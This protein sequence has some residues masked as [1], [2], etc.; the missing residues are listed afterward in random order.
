[1]SYLLRAL[2]KSQTDRGEAAM[3]EGGN[4]AFLPHVTPPAPARTR[5]LPLLLLSNGVLLTLI[6]SSLTVLYFRWADETERAEQLVVSARDTDGVSPQGGSIDA[7]GAGAPPKNEA[8]IG[9]SAEAPAWTAVADD[10]GSAGLR[11][12]WVLLKAASG[13]GVPVDH[14]WRPGLQPANWKTPTKS[15]FGPPQARLAL[16]PSSGRIPGG[17]R[18]L[19]LARPQQAEGTLPDPSQSPPLAPSALTPQV[20]ERSQAVPPSDDASGARQPEPALGEGVDALQAAV[21]RKSQDLLDPGAAIPRME[22]LPLSVLRD[23]P[24][25]V[26]SVHAYDP[27]PAKRFVRLNRAKR[28]AGDRVAKDLWLRNVTPEGVILRYRDTDFI[29][30]AN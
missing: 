30:P 29:L 28:K 19:H 21:A 14:L 12:D 26:I 5:A 22:Q 15:R 13:R 20:V 10:P 1:M 11:P 9:S 23:L 27:D 6:V 3:A 8:K 18:S 2:K 24:E 25:L 17:Y 4:V 7:A 16:S